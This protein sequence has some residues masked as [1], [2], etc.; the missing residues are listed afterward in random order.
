MNVTALSPIV[1]SVINE[2]RYVP[3]T[4]GVTGANVFDKV[5]DAIETS[6]K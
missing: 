6:A 2:K 3:T 4:V 1:I 5:L